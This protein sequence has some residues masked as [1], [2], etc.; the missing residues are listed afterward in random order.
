MGRPD[1]A[2]GGIGVPP[3]RLTAIAQAAVTEVLVAGMT[4][5]DATVG[6]GHDTLFLAR[7]VGDTGRVYGFD[8][9]A[10]ALDAARTRLAS[11]GLAGRV[12]LLQAGHEALAQRLP[13][14]L[15]GRVGAVMFNL[16]YLPGSDKHCI[17]Q[18]RTTLPALQL[19]ADWLAPG[20]LLTVL[21][22][23]GHAGGER[24]A[25]AVAEWCRGVDRRRYSLR[26]EAA[27]A[28]GGRGPE[29]WLL[30]RRP[31]PPAAA[32]HFP[33]PDQA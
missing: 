32:G 2:T 33:C 15:R 3:P 27:G 9:Q 24:E 8:V 26:H 18:A 6:N 5:V 22:Y 14:P 28:A 12:C 19:A 11:A 20:G 31:I 10:T 1:D 13:M 7:R 16:G 23:R 25:D 30:Y 17:T 29:L 21:A 4:A